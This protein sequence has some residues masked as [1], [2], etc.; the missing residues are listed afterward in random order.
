MECGTGCTFDVED[1]CS[2]D[3][4]PHLIVN[5]CEQT[6]PTSICM[7]YLCKALIV[8]VNKPLRETPILDSPFVTCTCICQPQPYNY[9]GGTFVFLE[10]L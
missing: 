6:P 10:T 5:A 7:L 3:F 1:R 9:K 2:R 4:I 8:P